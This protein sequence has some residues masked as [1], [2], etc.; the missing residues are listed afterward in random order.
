M[1]VVIAWAAIGLAAT[2]GGSCWFC[3]LFLPYDDSPHDVEH[4]SSG[5]PLTGIRRWISQRAEMVFSKPCRLLNRM[6]GRK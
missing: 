1:A 5:K 6:I 2:F 3:G 4:D